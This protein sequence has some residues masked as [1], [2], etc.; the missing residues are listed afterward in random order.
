MLARPEVEP[1][2]VRALPAWSA[3][4]ACG[5]SYGSVHPLVVSVVCDALG[6]DQEAWDRFATSPA[7]Y[8]GASAWLRLGDLLDSAVAGTPWPKPPGSR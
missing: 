3:L 7:T 2:L 6:S 5:G 1:E 8:A 4:Q